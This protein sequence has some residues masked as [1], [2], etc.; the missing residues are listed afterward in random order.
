M[1]EEAE[2]TEKL[3]QECSVESPGQCNVEKLETQ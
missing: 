2:A 1:I 3:G